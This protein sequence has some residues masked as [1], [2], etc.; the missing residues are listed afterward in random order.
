MLAEAGKDPS[1]PPI[2]NL[3]QYGFHTY[4]KDLFTAPAPVVRYLCRTS[5]VHEVP[6]GS[7]ETDK[8]S[9][10]IVNDPSC[11][12]S[13][14]F[15][16]QSVYSVMVSRYDKQAKGTRVTT[17][18]SPRYLTDSVDNDRLTA[19]KQQ[20]RDLTREVEQLGNQKMIHETQMKALRTEISECESQL[21]DLKTKKN[22]RST[23]QSLIK[24]ENT[25]RDNNKR[26]LEDARNRLDHAGQR[27]ATV[28]AKRAELHEKI[29]A[30]M[31]R[32]TQ[33]VSRTLRLKV[34]ALQAQRVVGLR[35][36]EHQEATKHLK[37]MKH[38]LADMKHDVDRSKNEARSLMNE[39]KK[40]SGVD[41]PTEEMD[42]AFKQLPG[43]LH[44]LVQSLYEE[45]AKM[46]C[47]VD[48]DEELVRQYMARKEEISQQEAELT[49]ETARREELVNKIE[50]VKG[51][52]LPPLRA[53][54]GK[55]SDSFSSYFR[56]LGCAGEVHL[57]EAEEF[58]KYGVEIRVK[59]REGDK[60]QQLTEH[61]QSGGE[62]A[63]STMLYL[64]ALQEQTTVRECADAPWAWA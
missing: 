35:D 56:E 49:A 26:A 58:D 1:S 50:E 62:R 2:G 10:D 54:I 55:I 22:E 6:V 38:Q 12:F 32:M 61:H 48:V 20:Q 31:A 44:D 11:G 4:V 28:D 34:D 9:E 29:V 57:Y 51:Q 45:Q 23:I 43:N 3:R 64:M 40:A 60:L 5:R 24:R 52:W 41:R 7:A 30:V 27:S 36:R 19:L 16:P 18:R 14:F 13:K 53:I 39:A 25:N 8:L 42:I 59:F 15:S 17:I 33:A 37:E 47:N 63:V 21:K 46:D